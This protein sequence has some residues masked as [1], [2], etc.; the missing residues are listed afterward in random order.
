MQTST[1]IALSYAY[2]FDC[3]FSLKNIFFMTNAKCI[4]YDSQSEPIEHMLGYQIDC[5]KI[6]NAYW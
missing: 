4:N 6:N 3:V 2:T 1:R 5:I